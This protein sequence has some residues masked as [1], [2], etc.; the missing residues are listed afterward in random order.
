MTENPED[1]KL[2][3]Y[4]CFLSFLPKKKNINPINLIKN[5]RKFINCDLI[6]IGGDTISESYGSYIIYRLF[7]T[8][9][10]LYLGIII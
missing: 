4:P 1:L 8:F 3:D 10:V 6:V 9:V 5:F 2:S 7:I